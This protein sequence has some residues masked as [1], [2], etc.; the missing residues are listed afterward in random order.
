MFRRLSLAATVALAAGC[1]LD[2]TAVPG[3]GHL[4]LDLDVAAA[5]Y[6]AQF[7]S[8]PRPTETRPADGKVTDRL[9]LPEALPGADAAPL[10]LPPADP[11]TP[12]AERIKAIT[13]AFGETPPL[14]PDPVPATPPMSLDQ[15]Q[16]DAADNHPVIRQA[17]AA[18]EAARGAALQAGLP[19]NPSIG[20]EADT[21]GSG[22]TAGQ[23]GAKL[24][25]LIKTAGKLKLAQAA[26]TMDVANAEVAL[27][28]ARLDLATQVRTAYYAVL[29]T[30]EQTRVAHALT[31]YADEALR[32]QVDLVKAGQAAAYEPLQLRALATQVRAGLTVA[33]NRH[34]AATRQLA[35]A[36]NRPDAT[37]PVLT[38]S[39]SEPVPDMPYEAVCERMLARHTDLRT[40]SN[41]VLKAQYH[42]R[43]AQ[44][45]PVPDVA[46]KLVVQKDFTTPP[47]N[48]TANV[49]VGVPIPVWDRNQGNVHQA[50]AEL[51]KAFEEAGRVRLELLAK[52][53]DA[54]ERYASNK[55]LVQAYQTQVL[56]DLVR[57]YRGVLERYEKAPDD[58]KFDDVLLAQQNLATALKDYLGYLAA[59]WTA[60]VDLAGLAQC[61]DLTEFTPKKLAT[62]EHR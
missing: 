27:R 44:V 11:A 52:L 41:S 62:D 51:G 9:K 26:A 3:S 46:L 38:G 31:R 47:F 6:N 60:V 17:V 29:V 37:C 22:G 18:V 1:R 28:K 10:K 45:T 16:R 12:K 30:Q 34:R 15:L 39:A 42:L 56:P 25:Q 53:A 13:D 54:T 58:V 7:P 36:I 43:L 20:F 21:V 49:E 32:V 40:A 8:P 33:H 57:G 23:Q 24:E 14:P 61:E 5:R 55:S 59:Q 19:P 4:D 35:A 48:T 50:M 2:T